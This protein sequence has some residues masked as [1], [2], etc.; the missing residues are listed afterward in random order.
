VLLKLIL[1]PCLILIA[2][3]AASG[4]N[5]A[6][7]LKQCKQRGTT[8]RRGCTSLWWSREGAATLA[9]WRAPM[10][11]ANR[12]HVAACLPRKLPRAT[13]TVVAV[14]RFGFR[15]LNDRA[16][17]RLRGPRRA[18]TGCRLASNEFGES[19][20]CSGPCSIEP[21]KGLRSQHL[22]TQV[23]SGCLA[24]RVLPRPP[25]LPIQ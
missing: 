10:A 7:D 9:S 16:L 3:F 25:H 12:T 4:I 13:K 1:I 5:T 2:L 24:L 6:K 19:H 8:T 22:P 15:I 23:S 11:V 20:E 18:M 14:P 21:Y 17:S